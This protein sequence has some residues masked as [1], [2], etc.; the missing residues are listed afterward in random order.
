MAK[1]QFNCIARKTAACTYIKKST[2]GFFNKLEYCERIKEVAD[3][4]ENIIRKY[5]PTEG[6][7]EDLFFFK[8]TR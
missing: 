7:V 3:D 6:V 5:S 2:L 1:Y 4:I 8:N